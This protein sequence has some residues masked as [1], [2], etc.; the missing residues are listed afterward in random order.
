[1]SGIL[2]HEL[3]NQGGNLEMH[4]ADLLS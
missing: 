4:Q 1:L 2:V 3:L